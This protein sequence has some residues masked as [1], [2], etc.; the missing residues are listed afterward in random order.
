MS[1]VWGPEA[2]LSDWIGNSIILMTGSLVF[3][4]FTKIDDPVLQI[5][6]FVAAF[7]SI[8]L[9]II[10]V[11]LSLTALIPYNSRIN[12]VLEHTKETHIDYQE[13][14][15]IK[16]MYTILISCF[17][18]LQIIICIYVIIDTIKRVEHRKKYFKK[19]K[20]KSKFNIFDYIA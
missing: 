4:G 7:V 6:P 2:Q 18:F 3:Y 5:N 11:C 1:I 8:G 17:I 12:K 15:N 16:F 14:E 20:S 13:E 9:I 10:D 19:R